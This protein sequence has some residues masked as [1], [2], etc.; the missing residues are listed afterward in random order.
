MPCAHDGIVHEPR[1]IGLD[2]QRGFCDGCDQRVVIAPDGSRFLDV[3]LGRLGG[4]PRGSFAMGAT[5]APAGRSAP[6]TNAAMSCGNTAA[7]IR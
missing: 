6:A 2:W 7:R 1:P 5:M 3:V 4:G